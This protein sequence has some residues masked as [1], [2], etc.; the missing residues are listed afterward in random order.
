MSALKRCGVRHAGDLTISIFSCAPALP[1]TG[2]A[3]V[4]AEN[5]AAGR[6]ERLAGP[7]ATRVAG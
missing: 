2:I 5:G 1:A 4:H 6:A 3:V 7:W